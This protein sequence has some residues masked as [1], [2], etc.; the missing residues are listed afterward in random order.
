MVFHSFVPLDE[1][2]VKALRFI[3][4]VC[5]IMAM[6]AIGL[7]IDFKK[8]AESGGRAFTLGLILF[9]I[10]YA[11]GFLLVKFFV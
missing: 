5:L 2:I 7:Q 8:F 6:S 10:L 9:V 3:S 4:E 1:F 11:G